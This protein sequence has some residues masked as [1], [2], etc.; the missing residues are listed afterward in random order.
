M[1]AEGMS[2]VQGLEAAG[3]AIFRDILSIDVD[4]YR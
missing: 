4:I 2:M 1:N 3:R